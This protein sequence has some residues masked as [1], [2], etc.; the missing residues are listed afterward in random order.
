MNTGSQQHGS[1]F[2]QEASRKGICEDRCLGFAWNSCEETISHVWYSQHS[3]PVIILPS[4]VSFMSPDYTWCECDAFWTKEGLVQGRKRRGQRV[5]GW[6]EGQL[7]AT[8]DPSPHRSHHT[9]SPTIRVLSCFT[10]NWNPEKTA[11]RPRLVPGDGSKSRS[12]HV[13]GDTEQPFQMAGATRRSL[14][15]THMESISFPGR[16]LKPS[17][18][19]SH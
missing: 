13:V 6:R 8:P 1:L 4:R 2:S 9:A 17:F 16:L 10:A 19:V 3:L 18:P 12:S 15:A 7:M 5:R 14:T 11:S